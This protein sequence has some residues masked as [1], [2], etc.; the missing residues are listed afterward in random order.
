MLQLTITTAF[1][2]PVLFLFSP[3]HP[4]TFKLHPTGQGHNEEHVVMRQQR[5]S[6]VFSEAEGAFL[7]QNT[8]LLENNSYFTGG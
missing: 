8:F 4:S 2:K 3:L 5:L 6:F 1:F 7:C